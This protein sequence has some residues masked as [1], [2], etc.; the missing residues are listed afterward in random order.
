M[1]DDELDR[2]EV[3]PL[4]VGAAYRALR[5]RGIQ[6]GQAS[7]VFLYPAG[8]SDEFRAELS[9]WVSDHKGSL[10]SLPRHGGSRGMGVADFGDDMNLL[11]FFKL[12][13]EGQLRLAN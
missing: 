9:S 6:V 3:T 12:W 10:H 1:E 13:W 11:V 8:V 4:R 7:R 2:L 5:R